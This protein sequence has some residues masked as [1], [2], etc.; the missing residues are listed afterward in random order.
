MRNLHSRDN[1][2]VSRILMGERIRYSYIIGIWKFYFLEFFAIYSSE[3]CKPDRFSEGTRFD[4]L[5]RIELKR[6]KKEKILSFTRTQLARR[7]ESWT[8]PVCL[9]E[10][11]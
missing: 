4:T 10:S 2:Y 6:K 3:C 1:S 9:L 8:R 11:V 7:R 5:R